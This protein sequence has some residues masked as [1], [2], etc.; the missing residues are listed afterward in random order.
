MGYGP[1]TLTHHKNSLVPYLSGGG[2]DDKYRGILSLGDARQKIS[3]GVGLLKKL[4]AGKK[5][6]IGKN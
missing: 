4:V 1:V 2:T 3:L 5:K 6:L